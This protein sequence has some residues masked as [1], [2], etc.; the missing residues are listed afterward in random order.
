[1]THQQANELPIQC[2]YCG[3]DR[4]RASMPEGTHNFWAVSCQGC[5]AMGPPAETRAEAIAAWNRRA[6]APTEPAVDRDA[7]QLDTYW[8][9]ADGVADRFVRVS[10]VQAWLA[11]PASPAVPA[12]FS[13][14][15][16]REY[17]NRD[18]RQCRFRMTSVRELMEAAFSAGKVVP[19]PAPLAPRRSMSMF[20]TL[21]DY[22]AAQASQ[23]TST[24][25]AVNLLVEEAKRVIGQDGGAEGGA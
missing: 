19:A 7:D 15:F 13:D 3:S 23:P 24:P 11:T 10:D 18:D 17:P 9:T 20:A 12:Q 4:I 25:E 6:P 22:R 5:E 2:V 21:E 14:W 1:M 16:E 8:L